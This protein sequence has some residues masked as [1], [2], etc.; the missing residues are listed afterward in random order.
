MGTCASASKEDA[1]KAA[2]NGIVASED[3]Y[4]KFGGSYEGDSKDTND[5]KYIT[6]SELPK[7]SQIH[8]SAMAKFL[9][10][11]VFEKLKNVKSS[12]GY[13]LSNAIMT[14][15]DDGMFRMKESTKSNSINLSQVSSHL[16]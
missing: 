9:T 13:T 16:I 6:Y 4:L 12:K 15:Q 1:E 11:E 2:A 14:G 8:K 5:F 10:Q 7:F 3:Q